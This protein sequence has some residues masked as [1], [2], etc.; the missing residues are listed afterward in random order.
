MCLYHSHQKEVS[1]SVM[2]Y[3]GNEI[4]PICSGE[5]PPSGD[6]GEYEYGDV[7]SGCIEQHYQ[8]KHNPIIIVRIMVGACDVVGVESINSE[9]VKDGIY[10]LTIFQ[11]LIA[12]M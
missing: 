10:A 1:K 8:Q 12:V 2:E 9:S 11:S 6:S 3:S 4:C 7:K 5:E